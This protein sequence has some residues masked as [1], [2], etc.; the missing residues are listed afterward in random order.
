[1]KKY[2]FVFILSIQFLSAQKYQSFDTTSVWR[3]IKIY[4]PSCYDIH[5]NYTRGYIL[6]NGYMWHKLYANILNGPPCSYNAATAAQEVFVGFYANDTLSK[7][8]YFVSSP[9]LIASFTPGPND[10]S[11]DFNRNLG[12]IFPL[13]SGLNY[14]IVT[15]DSVQLGIKYHKRFIGVTTSTTNYSPYYAY[16]IE[17]VGS[18]MGVFQRGFN[19][20]NAALGA[21]YHLTCFNSSAYSKYLVSNT[22]DFQ[23][24]PTDIRDTNNCGALITGIPYLSQQMERMVI[25]PSPA[26]HFLTIESNFLEEKNEVNITDIYG[27]LIKRTKMPEDNKVDV[28]DL[29]KGIYSLSV[30][31]GNDVLY[32]TK[33]IKE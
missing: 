28:S 15:I 26:V 10:V 30:L 1:M 20:F 32:M 29:E 3:N 22:A 14:K 24:H 31:K 12:D 16:I 7:K 33:I 9:I 11:Y 4:S 19:P 17:G 21:A 13:Y 5:F 6:L 23:S 2:L 18:S 25:Y 27:R 8:A